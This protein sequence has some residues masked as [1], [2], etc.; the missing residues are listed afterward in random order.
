MTTEKE[1]VFLE[2]KDCHREFEF[3]GGEQLYFEKN[4]L[5]PPKRCGMCRMRKRMRYEE[6]EHQTET[7]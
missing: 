3:T 1:S 7:V 6:A 5:N 2:C 4:G